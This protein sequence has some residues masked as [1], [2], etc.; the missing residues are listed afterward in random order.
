M[1]FGHWKLTCWKTPARMKILR[2]SICSVDASTG[3]TKVLACEDSV[4]AVIS[5]VYKGNFFYSGGHGQN[6]ASANFPNRNCACL[7][8]LFQY[9]EGQRGLNVQQ[10]ITGTQSNTPMT[11]TPPPTSPSFILTQVLFKKKVSIHMKMRN[12]RRCCQ[13]HVKPTGG[14]ITPTL[15][16]AWP[17][18]KATCN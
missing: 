16:P 9:I 12:T 14:D 7:Q 18:L 13:E 5:F 4:C 3:K 6:T 1:R 2:N 8:L 11:Q 15:K 17:Y 10:E